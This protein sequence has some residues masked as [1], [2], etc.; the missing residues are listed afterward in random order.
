M[1]FEY[2]LGQS[3]LTSLAERVSRF[4]VILKKLNKPTKPV[5]GTIMK[6]INGLPY[7]ARRSVTFDRGTGFVSWPHLQAE[8]GTQT[9][10][11]DPLSPWQKAQSKTRTG[12]PGTGFVTS[13]TLGQ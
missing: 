11:C 9:Q 7:I 12:A 6:A 13:A 8:P 10:F 4:T 3:N 1:L 2:K 5:M